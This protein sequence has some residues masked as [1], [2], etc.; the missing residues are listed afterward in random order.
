MRIKTPLT[1]ENVKNHFTYSSWKYLIVIVVGIMGWSLIYTTTAYRSPQDKRIDLYIQSATTSNEMID[2]F[3][4]PIWEETVP[5]MEVV[6]G[7]SL[8]SA[9]DYTTTMQLT[10][11]VFAGEGDI[12]FVT[13][14]YFKS[15]AS[16]GAFL[17]LEDM[18]AD[19]TLQLEGIDLQKGYL[20]VVEEYDDQD[21]PLSTSQ[22]LYGIPLDS[23]YGF[24]NGM[25]LDNRGMYAAILVNNQND[26]HVIPFFNALLQAGRGEK[27]NWITE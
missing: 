5:D 11:Y 26:D 13:D 19:G 8:V 7:L 10:T 6:Q 15:L 9:D 4:K 20:T 14:Q 18:V 21:Q 2:A 3:L 16:S 23:F 24:M 27:E 25:M 22:H 17:P 12:Y 1:K